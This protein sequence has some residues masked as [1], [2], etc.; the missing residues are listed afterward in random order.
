MSAPSGFSISWRSRRRHKRRGASPKSGSAGSSAA[1]G[2]VE[3]R[4]PKRWRASTPPATSSVARSHPPASS[5]FGRRTPSSAVLRPAVKGLLP[6]RRHLSRRAPGLLLAQHADDLRL[7]EPALLHVRLLRRTDAHSKRGISN[8]PGH[9]VLA[10][11]VHCREAS[12]RRPDPHRLVAKA[13]RYG[14]ATW[15][16]ARTSLARPTAAR[17]WS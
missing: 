11:G 17:R 6:C 15:P 12:C 9:R 4:R 10:S 3:S 16:P 14:I 1:T 8:V 5:A 13:G 7:V 2:S